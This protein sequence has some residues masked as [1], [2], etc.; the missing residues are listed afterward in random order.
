MKRNVFRIGFYAFDLLML[1][2]F[3]A[4]LKHCMWFDSKWQLVSMHILLFL[5]LAVPFLMYRRVWWSIIPM[6]V[7]TALFAPFLWTDAFANLIYNMGLF[8][9]VVLHRPELLRGYNALSDMTHGEFLVWL[10]VAW[11]WVA[12]FIA[13]AVQRFRLKFAVSASFKFAIRKREKS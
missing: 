5:R 12:P 10:L 8:P 3:F 4:C 6:A 7:A 1:L 11:I 2:A 9:S 13:Y